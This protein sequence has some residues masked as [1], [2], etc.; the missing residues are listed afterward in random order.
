MH[1]LD[2]GQMAEQRAMRVQRA[3]RVARGAGGVDDDGGIVGRCIDGGEFFRS[4]FDRGPERFGAGMDRARRHVDV[5]QIR[6]PVADLCEFLPAG[7][8]GD[9]GLGAG[10]GQAKLQRILAE[11]REQRHRD[12]AGTKRRQMR[13]RQFQR[14]R[15]EHRDAVAA[16]EPIRLQHIG[17]G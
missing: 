6:Q 13:D 1:H 17:K 10:I 4:I 11:Q 5:L 8:V 15:Q 9:H 3:L 12:Q 2:A 7:L 14:L 16:H